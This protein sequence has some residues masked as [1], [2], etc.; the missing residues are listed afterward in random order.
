MSG[1]RAVRVVAFLVGIVGAVCVWRAPTLD[2]SEGMFW[3]ISAGGMAL[4]VLAAGVWRRSGGG[5]GQ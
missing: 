2:V 3:L 1:K 5:T 4:C